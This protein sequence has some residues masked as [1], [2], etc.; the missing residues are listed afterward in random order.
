MLGYSTISNVLPCVFL[1][2]P[3]IVPRGTTEIGAEPEYGMIHLIDGLMTCTY[4]YA[5]S[6]FVWLFC[7]RFPYDLW[8]ECVHVT[9]TFVTT[10]EFLEVKCFSVPG[11]EWELYVVLTLWI[12]NS[13]YHGFSNCFW[14]TD[15]RTCSK[16]CVR[17]FMEGLLSSENVRRKIDP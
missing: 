10:I 9:K 17:V 4:F 16:L 11:V 13:N 12:W 8:T 7:S 5:Y 14:K 6:Y 2:A 15:W 3:L 1:P